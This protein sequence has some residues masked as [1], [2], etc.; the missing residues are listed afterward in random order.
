MRGPRMR[1]TGEGMVAPGAV[2]AANL[3]RMLGNFATANHEV[4]SP[5]QAAEAARAILSAGGDGIKIH[6][7]RPIPEPAIRAAVEV[8]HRSGKPVFVHPSTTADALA[9]AN[10]GVDVL[11][12]TTPF[13]GWDAS[14]IPRLLEKKV[15]I[16][17]AGASCG[18]MV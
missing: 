10:A 16:T 4:T 2:P 3:L 8:A 6:L 14:V 9:A 7:Q 11:A 1:T 13:S 12:H 17:P 15:A 5:D 18:R